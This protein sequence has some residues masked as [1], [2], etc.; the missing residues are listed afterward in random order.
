M[1]LPS[2]DIDGQN[3][4][5]SACLVTWTG[6]PA[7]R[8]NLVDVVDAQAHFGA[9]GL[10]VLLVRQRIGDVI[11]R[12]VGAPHR[13]VAVVSLVGEQLRVALVGE[14]RH[15]QIRGEAAAIVPARPGRGMAIE[16]Q[17]LAVGR[18]AAR[19][20]PVGRQRLFLPAVDRDLMQR[21][22]VRKRAEPARG[23][24]HDALAVAAPAHHFIVAA[25]ERQ[26]LRRAARAESRRR[27]CCRS[28]S[29]RRRSTCRPARSADRCR[30]RCDR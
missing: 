2:L 13:P 21:R 5:P 30:A 20:A 10:D 1:V 19:P 3:R 18:E 26:L 25:V 8:G 14:V 15:P 4:L 23:A 27:R 28:D 11:D 9:A 12:I 6:W 16:D 24:E 17:R 7:L 29:T 22:D